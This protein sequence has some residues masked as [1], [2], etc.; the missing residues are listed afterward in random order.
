MGMAL[1]TGQEPRLSR[2][3]RDEQARSV[4]VDTAM[5]DATL[6]CSRGGTVGAGG[7]AEQ[8]ALRRRVSTVHG[9][10]VAAFGGGPRRAVAFRRAI[11]DGGWS[12]SAP[13]NGIRAPPC[14]NA[15]A[16][17]EVWIAGTRQRKIDENGGS[18]DVRGA[19]GAVRR[20]R[21]RGGDDV[22]A[23]RRGASALARRGGG[24][25]G[26]MAAPAEAA[27]AVASPWGGTM[28]PWPAPP[29]IGGY[30]RPPRPQSRNVP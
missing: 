12:Q 1:G 16:P 15:T 6:A 13:T 29:P 21:R 2:L 27:E 18:S 20:E 8:I 26:G 4:V 10:A 14:H 28:P 24:G 7:A 3:V 25:R 9:R 17:R 23:R 11:G 30:L 22:P 5:G 19:C